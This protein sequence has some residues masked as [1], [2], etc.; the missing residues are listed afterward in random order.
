M[1]AT[2]AMYTSLQ[3]LQSI[4]RYNPHPATAATI[5]TP[6]Q[7]LQSTP[8]YSC[9]TL[10]PATAATMYSP[11]HLLHTTPSYSCYNVLPTTPAA[12]YTQLHLLHTT[13]SY[14]CYN[15]HPTTPAAH[16]TQ[17][18]LL[19]CTPAT[20][21]AISMSFKS[22]SGYRSS[23]LQPTLSYSCCYSCCDLHYSCD[24]S[25]P[26]TTAAHKIS[27]HNEHPPTSAILPNYSATM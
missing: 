3:L 22:G 27:L 9:C 25:H 1:T 7:L 18:Q 16:Y 14:S 5:H 2:T 8:H 6:L 21:A 4:P 24:T 26:I 13:P 10:D 23:K 12:H 17:L 11:L 20:T 15:V 19:Q